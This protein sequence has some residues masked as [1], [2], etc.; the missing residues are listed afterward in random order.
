[1]ENFTDV[2]AAIIALEIFLFVYIGIPILVIYAIVSHRKKV[3]FKKEELKKYTHHK[4][5][6]STRTSVPYSQTPHYKNNTRAYTP[7]KPLSIPSYM[8][9]PSSEERKG[10]FGEYLLVQALKE[11]PGE[12]RILTNCY[13]PKEDGT[14]TELDI[15]MIH[16]TGIYVIESKNYSGWV[17][18]TDTDTNWT[19]TYPNGQ[20]YQFYNPIM[21][22]VNHIKHLKNLIGDDLFYFSF[23]VFGKNCELKN[24]LNRTQTAVCDIITFKGKLYATLTTVPPSL[25]ADKIKSLHIK[26][27][28]YE[29]AT[30]EEKEKHIQTIKGDLNE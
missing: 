6:T 30:R 23:V 20:K 25:N 27:S 8:K 10:T 13:I 16:E 11:M 21:Q 5:Y 2:F 7:V 4:S 29:Y 28:E 17:F 14:T 12:K 22:N 1:M 3:K 19:L 24:I 15:V 9:K 18:G 26:L